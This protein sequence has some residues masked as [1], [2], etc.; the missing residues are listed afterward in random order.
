MELE[1]SHNAA[2]IFFQQAAREELRD[3]PR[4]MVQR[5]GS[6]TEVTWGELAVR[7]ERLAS[8]LIDRGVNADTKVAIMANTR[9]EWAVSVLA[10]MAARGTLVPV[11]PT[12]TA[13]HLAHILGHSD[14]RVL[15]VETSEHL[16][17]VLQV[18]DK[19]SLETLV[20]L[21]PM[22]VKA[23]AEAAGLDAEA[24]A[25]RAFTLGQAEEL[26]TGT[27]AK[28]PDKTRTSRISSTPRGPPACPR[29]CR[30]PTSTRG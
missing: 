17:R 1:H 20:T 12:L 14:S 8:F 16:E 3:K 15:V 5:E 18:W 28:A 24:M 22:D 21:E 9:L 27:L 23:A 19:L 29:A 30:F 2:N 6:W 25:D 10:L 4:F 7:I 13:E 11:Y 26:G